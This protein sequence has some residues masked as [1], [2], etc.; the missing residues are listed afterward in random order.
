LEL[1]AWYTSQR[2]QKPRLLSPVGSV[3]CQ[4]ILLGRLDDRRR[5]FWATLGV[6]LDAANYLWAGVN[7]ANTTRQ[8][9]E[10]AFWFPALSRAAG[11]R[12]L[13]GM[14]NEDFGSYGRPDPIS[15]VGVNTHGYMTL[16][17][18]PVTW[19]GYRRIDTFFREGK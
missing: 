6:D 14:L 7:H 17:S 1:R 4:E 10:L 18:F 16:S 15:P 3:S 13:A 9:A 2:I 8:W 11:S 19:G 12:P 5:R